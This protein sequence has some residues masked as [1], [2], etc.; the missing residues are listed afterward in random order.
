MSNN[1]SSTK[2]TL[3]QVTHHNM[4]NQD[5]QDANSDNNSDEAQDT[6]PHEDYDVLFDYQAIDM[7]QDKNA[8]FL[9][10][11][12]SALQCITEHSTGIPLLSVEA[13]ETWLLQ[14]FKQHYNLDLRVF[15]GTVYANILRTA[16]IICNKYTALKI[17]TNWNILGSHCPR[18]LLLFLLVESRQEG[19]PV[20]P[21]SLMCSAHLLGMNNRNKTQLFDLH[22]DSMATIIS[23]ESI[24][25][26]SRA[27]VATMSHI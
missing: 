26:I 20:L 16:K 10:L 5:N 3:A 1:I 12:V 2:R 11:A 6:A 19:R 23:L 15:P 17:K 18:Q 27:S 25:A 22:R 14:I 4:A 9:A 8:Q 24:H 21:G 7:L 13:C